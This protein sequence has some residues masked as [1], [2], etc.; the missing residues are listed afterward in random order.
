MEADA[1]ERRLWISLRYDGFPDLLIVVL[2][3]RQTFPRR[4]CQVAQILR[5]AGLLPGLDP[6][7]RSSAAVQEAMT[8]VTRLDDVA[9][10]RESVQQC[11]GHLRVAEHGGRDAACLSLALARATPEQAQCFRDDAQASA[12]G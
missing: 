5:C 11:R 6:L 1:L 7:L 3:S 9:V 2:L 10:M 8:L 4:L 12:D